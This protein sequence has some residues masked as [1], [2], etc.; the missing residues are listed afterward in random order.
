M[1]VHQ[2]EAAEHVK[3]GVGTV[4]AAGFTRPQVLDSRTITDNAWTTDYATSTE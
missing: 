2:S 1:S 3:R 4:L